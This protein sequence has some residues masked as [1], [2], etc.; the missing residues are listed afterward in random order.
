MMCN[1][2]TVN[3]LWTGGWDSTYRLVELSRKFITIQP[4]YVYGDGR[5]SEYYERVA[6]QKILKGL[7]ARTETIATILSTKFIHLDMIPQNKEITNAY[8]QIN[9]DT[10][11]GSQH[12][13][14]ARLAYIYPGLEIGTEAGSP[15]T[16]R[17]IN[18]I[19]K[20]GGGVV[21]D[22]FNENYILNPI[23]STKEG[24]LVLGNFKYPIIDKTEIDMKRNIS[25]WGY[26]DIM[27]YIWFCHTPIYGKPCGICHPCEV[28]IESG[29]ENLLPK[30]AIRR[31][32]KNNKSPFKFLY[33]NVR[34]I[35]N[36]ISMLR[37]KKGRHNL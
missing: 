14:L 26:E 13:W 25:A 11:L 24:M 7:Q 23:K 20:Y 8:Q 22:S 10:K 2:Q 32:Y 30:S 9:I 6:M 35:N 29:M 19:Q 1:K 15:E 27:D 36:K 17:I 16:S 4:I 3:L 28:K 5:L 18:S 33:K 37:L 31:Y 12:E 21:K 34:R